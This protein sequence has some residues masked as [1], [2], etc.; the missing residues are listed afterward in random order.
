MINAN[1]RRMS[2]LSLSLAKS[3]LQTVSNAKVMAATISGL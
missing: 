3:D 2:S 1:F